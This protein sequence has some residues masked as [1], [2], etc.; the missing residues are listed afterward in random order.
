MKS[1]L[2]DLSATQEDVAL[3]T[4]AIN[5]EHDNVASI[6]RLIGSQNEIIAEVVAGTPDGTVIQSQRE[7]LLAAIAVGEK[8]REDLD[9]FEK[10]V[11]VIEDSTAD[12]IEQSRHAKAAIAG[13]ERK[14]SAAVE[15]LEVAKAE[16][17]DVC[18]RFIASGYQKDLKAYKRHAEAT[19]KVYSKLIGYE[20]V[21]SQAGLRGSL[22]S[23]STSLKIP[24][25]RY[26]DDWADRKKACLFDKYMIDR[27]A[28]EAAI[29]TELQL[30]GVEV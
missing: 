27:I 22:I 30:S 3:A 11:T 16:Y 28:F 7:D 26:M 19:V 2:D 18:K 20:R 17:T 9:N 29:K 1:I 4:K 8:T 23:E 24:K 21:L 6:D 14:R 25:F 10:Q 5:S 12:A 13:L 15:V